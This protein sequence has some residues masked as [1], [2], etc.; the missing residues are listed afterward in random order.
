M[1]VVY[2]A[3]LPV[4]R[5][6]CI[7]LPLLT[8]ARVGSAQSTRVPVSRGLGSAGASLYDAVAIR[9]LPMSCL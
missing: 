8:C 5:C 7:E 2:L 1:V 4:S 3:Y 6:H 9:G